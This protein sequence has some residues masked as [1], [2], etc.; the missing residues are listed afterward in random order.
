MPAA[1]GKASFYTRTVQLH[2]GPKGRQL[3]A[4]LLTPPWESFRNLV[5]KP[6]RGETDYRPVRAR[7]PRYDTIGHMRFRKLRI[8]WSVI[9]GLACVLTLVLWV[10]SY[11]YLDMLKAPWRGSRSFQ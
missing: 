1:N 6:Q 5:V 10:L 8:A 4:R 2:S 3:I 7:R 11:W 9:C